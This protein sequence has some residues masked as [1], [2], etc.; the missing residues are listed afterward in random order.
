MQHLF[1]VA[2]FPLENMPYCSSSKGYSDGANRLLSGAIQILKSPISLKR[3]PCQGCRVAGW[4]F[5]VWLGLC[6]TSSLKRPRHTDVS[7]TRDTRYIGHRLSITISMFEMRTLRAVFDHHQVPIAHRHTLRAHTTV[8]LQTCQRLA[9][10]KTMLASMT[11][12][13]PCLVSC[14]NRLITSFATSCMYTF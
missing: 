13:C 10:F 6:F 8:I 9:C 12:R 5:L 11:W 7:P 14:V 1:G 2:P 4:D 3:R